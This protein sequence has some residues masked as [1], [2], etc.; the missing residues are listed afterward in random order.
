MLTSFSIVTESIL[1]HFR[2]QTMQYE[3]DKERECHQAFDVCPY[4]THKNVNPDRVDGTCSWVLE[5][6]RYIH[7]CQ[8][9][10]DGLLWISA[11]PGCGKSV[12]SKSLIDRELQ[13]SGSHTVCYFFFKDNEDQDSIT[14]ALCAILHQ[15]FS[16]RP[17]L[18]RYAIPKWEQMKNTLRANA[19]ELWR[20]FI[21]VA[22]A[23]DAENVT[24]VFDALDECDKRGRNTLITFLNDFYKKSQHQQ[25]RLS[26]LKILATS[27]PYHDIE[28]MFQEII[29]RFPVVRLQG[30]LENAQI[31]EEINLVIDTKVAEMAKQLQLKPSDR[32][33]I[34]RKHTEYRTSHLSLA[35]PCSK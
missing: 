6:P 24:C 21:K 11:D 25:Q 4:E 20:V 10:W 5:N 35:I 12:L 16:K 34:V 22:T 28:I 7:W 26:R 23:E 32:D 9:K 33:S 13:D 17:K 14:K 1:D 18:I 30:E 29:S 8:S 27:R 2:R 31:E 19:D 15:L 3:N